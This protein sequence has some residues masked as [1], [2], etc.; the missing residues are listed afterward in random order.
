MTR[1]PRLPKLF[2]P[3][4]LAFEGRCTVLPGDNRVTCPVGVA[5]RLNLGLLPTAEGS[6]TVAALALKEPVS[7]ADLRWIHVH[8]NVD[9]GSFSFEM[10]ECYG[11]LVAICRIDNVSFLPSFRYAFLKSQSAGSR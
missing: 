3:L 1:S 2:F 9:R 4:C 6:Y 7:A 8:A 11:T 5:H 10:F